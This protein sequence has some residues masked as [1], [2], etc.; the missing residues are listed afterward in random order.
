MTAHPGPTAFV[1]AAQDE[2]DQRG[3]AVARGRAISRNV[4]PRPYGCAATSRPRP[5]GFARCGVLVEMV[6]A[7]DACVVCGAACATAGVATVVMAAAVMAMR[8]ILF[9]GTPI[10]THST[11]W[12]LVVRS[13]TKIHLCGMALG[14]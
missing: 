10:A 7:V 9:M 12:L 5:Y 3:L 1:A 13:R 14:G 11:I 2:S 6:R 4:L 8:W